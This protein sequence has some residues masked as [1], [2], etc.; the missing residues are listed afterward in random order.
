MAN[1]EGSSE[2]GGE[3]KGRFNWYFGVFKELIVAFS[4]VLGLGKGT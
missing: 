1:G 2:S 4:S 3:S